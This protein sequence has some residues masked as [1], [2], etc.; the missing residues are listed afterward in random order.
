MKRLLSTLFV[1]LF[2]CAAAVSAQAKAETLRLRADIDALTAPEMAGRGI[3]TAGGDLAIRYLVERMRAMGLE[4]LDGL[5]GYQQH[6]D[7]RSPMGAAYEQSATSLS[8]SIGPRNFELSLPEEALPF[9]FSPDGELAGELVFAGYGLVVDG[10]RNDFD[11]LE[12]KGK[13]ALVLRSLPAELSPLLEGKTGEVWQEARRFRTKIA[14][15]AEA[16]AAG[17]LLVGNRAMSAESDRRQIAM[18]LHAKGAAAIPSFWITRA[19][20]DRLLGGKGRLKIRQAREAREERVGG[21]ERQPNAR[22]ATKLKLRL[23]M[24]DRPAPLRTANV[25]GLLRGREKPDEFLVIG[26]HHDHLGTGEFGSLGTGAQL[27]RV[28]PGADDNAAGVAA[29]LAMAQR[30]IS[31]PKELRPRRS[32]LFVSFGAEELYIRGSRH[33]WLHCPVPRRQIVGMLNMDM[34][35]RARSQG[36]QIQGLGSAASFAAQI[37]TAKAQTQLKLCVL[38]TA[39]SRSDH[40]AFLNGGVPS[41]FFHS[42]LHD[43]YHRPGDVAKLIE[44]DGVQQVLSLVL[45]V[46]E[47]IA[48]QKGRPVFERGI[49]RRSYPRSRRKK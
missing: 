11:G 44:V 37:A 47:A 5:E 27:G 26:A 9:G 32:I 6:F 36:L 20:A 39:A 15:A 45:E 35:G 4:S 17:F 13:V 1:S 40:W 21:P 2:A 46:A 16:G 14:A 28:H 24:A 48:D 33:F 31:R 12:L 7:T 10:V 18:A 42:G 41:L 23:R 43:Q 30:L 34:I 25:V 29:L 3:G 38:D 22:T 49:V 8:A 19:A